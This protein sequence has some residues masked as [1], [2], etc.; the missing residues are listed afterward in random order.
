MFQSSWGFRNRRCPSHS[1]LE[2][3]LIEL[4]D[5]FLVTRFL[6]KVGD[7]QRNWKKGYDKI[8]IQ[9]ICKFLKAHKISLFETKNQFVSFKRIL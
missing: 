5:W 7:F 1:D 3:L 8:K 4:G 6:K 9:L 2:I